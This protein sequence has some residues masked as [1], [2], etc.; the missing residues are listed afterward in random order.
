[1]FLATARTA[2]AAV[3]VFLPVVVRAD[4]LPKK[5]DPVDKIE[6]AWEPLANWWTSISHWWTYSKGCLDADILTPACQPFWAWTIGAVLVVAVLVLA[7]I[8]VKLISYMMKLAA[9]RKAEAERAKVADEAT[10]RAHAWEGDSAY[11]VDVSAEDLQ[12]RIKDALVSRAN[13]GRPPPVV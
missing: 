1:M 13:E 10:I 7:W 3:V 9:A 2:L 8:L 5:S 4:L 11:Q 12:R 6:P